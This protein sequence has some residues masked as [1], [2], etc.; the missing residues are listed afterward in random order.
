MEAGLPGRAEGG[1]KDVG[2]NNWAVSPRRSAT[3]HAL[4]AGD[5]HLDLTL[6]SIWYE[7]QL[8]VPGVLDV[9]GVTIPGAPAIVIGFNRDVAW[10]FTNTGNDVL[11]LYAETLD[12][13]VH[14]ARYQLEGAC[15]HVEPRIDTYREAGLT[16][17][18]LLPSPPGGF[19]PLYEDHFPVESLSQ[20][21]EFDFPAL[22]GGFSDA[23]E[24]LGV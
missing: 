8:T 24:L 11:D 4:L 18:H 16:G 2:S 7:A 15:H 23:I 22:L 21:P 17:V 19:Y 6:P 13:P 9:N 5:P 10:S 12:D 14:P 20:L 1:S 3:H